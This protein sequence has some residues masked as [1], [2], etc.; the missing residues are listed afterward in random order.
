LKLQ[1]HKSGKILVGS[2]NAS[3][4]IFNWRTKDEAVE[5][6]RFKNNFN[7]IRS[8]S[9]SHNGK[10]LVYTNDAGEIFHFAIKTK[11]SG[12]VFEKGESSKIVKID[13][14][15]SNSTNK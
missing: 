15:E 5:K 7:T 2:N 6:I 10:H 1:L 11:E 4:Y 3:A 8:V 13:A 12:E 9:L 14:I